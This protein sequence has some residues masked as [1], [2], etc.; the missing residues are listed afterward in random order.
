MTG[1]AFILLPTGE[2][3]TGT[4]DFFSLFPFSMFPNK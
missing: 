1:V 2:K 4:E 3:H